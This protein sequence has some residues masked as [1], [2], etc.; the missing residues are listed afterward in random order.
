MENSSREPGIIGEDIC[1]QAAAARGSLRAEEQKG[2]RV[3]VRCDERERH[4]SVI[5]WIPALEQD[6]AKG[7]ADIA[8]RILERLSDGK[9]RVQPGGIGPQGMPHARRCVCSHRQASDRRGCE[10]LGL[11]RVG[12]RWRLGGQCPQ[13]SGGEGASCLRVDAEGDAQ[14]AE[15]KIFS[16][17]YRQTNVDTM[18]SARAVKAV[19][20]APASSSPGCTIEAMTR[21]PRRASSPGKGRT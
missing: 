19:S 9:V 17:A 5:Q 11:R 15:R 10:R 16:H 6:S 7:T 3:L 18:E 12:D 14:P 1:D 21:M 8:V 2:R 13:E 4:R 20:A